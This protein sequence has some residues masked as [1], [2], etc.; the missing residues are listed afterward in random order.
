[1]LC[2]TGAPIEAL[3][4]VGQNGAGRIPTD[5]DLKGDTAVAAGYIIVYQ[6]VRGKYG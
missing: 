6:D 3:D 5:D 2:F 1:V 4:L